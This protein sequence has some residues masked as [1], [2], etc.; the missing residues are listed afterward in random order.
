MRETK[1]RKM[2]NVGVTKI[3]ALDREHAFTGEMDLPILISSKSMPWNK[4]ST[5]V[6]LTLRLRQLETH[7]SMSL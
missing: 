3:E 6:G 1:A 7:S 4:E 5:D 2:V